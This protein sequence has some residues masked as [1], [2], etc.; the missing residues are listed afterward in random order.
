MGHIR[1]GADIGGTFTDIVV[2]D[3]TG[4][5]V[6]K[7][8]S[9]TVDNYARGIT[10]GLTELFEEHGLNSEDVLEVLHG[11]TVA[12]NA[13]LEFKGARTGLITTK[14]FRDVLELQFPPDMA[15]LPAEPNRLSNQ[16]LVHTFEEEWG[17]VHE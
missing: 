14:G 16:T 4:A 13:I 15:R 9:S 8:V 1:V 17:K 11:T 3:E 12:S 10:A 5:V 7:K 6:T 2:M